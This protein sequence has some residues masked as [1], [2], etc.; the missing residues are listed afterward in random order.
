LYKEV[1][2]VIK[3]ITDI[4]FW[5]RCECCIKNQ[6]EILI[7]CVAASYWLVLI[8]QDMEICG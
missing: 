8:G 3:Y 2:N 4:S 6:Q 1:C 5:I 7:A